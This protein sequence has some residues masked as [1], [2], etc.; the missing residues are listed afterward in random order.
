LSGL[1]EM[2]MSGLSSYFV[3]AFLSWVALCLRN[4]VMAFAYDVCLRHSS[5]GCIW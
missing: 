4:L 3:L 2:F 1:F 5:M